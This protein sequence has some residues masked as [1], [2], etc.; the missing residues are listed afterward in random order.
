MLALLVLSALP[1]RAD[2]G[3][4]DLG[5]TNKFVASVN[6][7]VNIS[8]NSVFLP[9]VDAV[10][11]EMR[12]QGD[13]AGTGLITATFARSVD[14]VYWETTPRFTF[15]AALNGTTAVVAYTNLVNSIIGPAAYLKCISVTNADGT[16][17]AT[18]AVIRVIRKTLKPSP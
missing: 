12:F 2:V 9:K 5:V 4:V 8:S 17:N 10:G 13:A 7:T 3:V 6:T 14:G 16:A 15:I 18:N 11:L 1:S